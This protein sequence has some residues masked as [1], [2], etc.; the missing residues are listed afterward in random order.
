MSDNDKSTDM[1]SAVARAICIAR[2][3]DRQL[4]GEPSEADV[5]EVRHLAKAAIAALKDFRTVHSAADIPVRAVAYNEADG[6]IVA[7][8]DQ[9]HGVVFGD[10]RP[11]PWQDRYLRGP[12]RVLWHPSDGP[13]A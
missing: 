8:F 1:E 11:F 3:N 4:D 10:D 9:E 6:S 7:R 12:F 13:S 5:E 2:F